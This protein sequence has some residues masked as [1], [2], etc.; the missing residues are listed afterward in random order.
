M[1][2]HYNGSTKYSNVKG[3]LIIHVLWNRDKIFI[4]TNEEKGIETYM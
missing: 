4:H 1:Q 2:G 3:N